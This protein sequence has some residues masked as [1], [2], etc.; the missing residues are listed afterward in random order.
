MSNLLLGASFSLR[1]ETNLG[2]NISLLSIGP[3]QE[4]NIA[5]FMSRNFGK[6]VSVFVKPA[7]QN[8][9]VRAYPSLGGFLFQSG[10][11]YIGY[12]FKL[13]LVYES[14]VVSNQRR[15][16]LLAS[17]QRELGSNWVMGFHARQY[18]EMPWF[19]TVDASVRLD[20]NQVLQLGSGG[21]H[22]FFLRYG[23]KR[24]RWTMN[25]SLTYGAIAGLAP[26]NGWSYAW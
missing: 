22:F 26:E 24:G 14:L 20:D 15:N 23:R 2:F 21:R 16:L 7:Y 13:A 17:F 11:K 19:F 18:T 4:R 10:I 3:Y 5:V 9:Q 1:S 12:P 8:Q 6:R 25:V